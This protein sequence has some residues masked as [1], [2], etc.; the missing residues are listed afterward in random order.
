MT[1]LRTNAEV[2]TG[3]PLV[4]DLD[5]TLICAD[6]LHES[7]L[8][9]L[10]QDP[11]AALRM[12]WWLQ[13]GRA[14]LKHEIAQRVTLDVETLPY[15]TG[16]LEWLKTQRAAGRRLVLCTASNERYAQQVAAHLALFDEVIASDATVNV[17]AQRKAQML[18][19]RFGAKGFDY[20]GNSAD[21]LQV[22]PHARKAIV[23]NAKSSVAAE[24]RQR[25]EV[26]A[27]WPPVK[28]GARGLL[29]AMRLHQWMKNLLLLLPLAGAYQLGDVHLLGQALVAFLAFGLCASSVYV[30][31]DLMDLASDR[32]HPRKRLRPFASGL[33][34]VPQGLVFSA[35]LLAGSVVLALA[36]RPA[37]QAALALYFAMTLAY[38][39]VLKQR[40]IVDCVTLGGL[41]TIRIVAGWCAVGL[42]PSFW[43]L[44]FS[45]FLFLSLAFVKRF[46]ELQLMVKMGRAETR[47]RGY[48]ASDLPIV[49]SMGIAAGFGSVL[50][51][52]LYINGDT[53]L[54]SYTRLELLWCTVPV[55]LYWVSRMWMQAQRG[56][57]HDDPVV[58]A[59]RDWQSVACGALF[60]LALGL[61]R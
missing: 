48:I 38:T 7:T 46:S 39:F 12:P 16:L 4:V 54:R 35:V 45:L 41:Y 37:F 15:H 29:R 56:N 31:N 59:L 30:L 11:I 26:A 40:V 44:A 27:A 33:L 57:M 53:V 13:R 1:M 23:V 28:A 43:L 60:V 21:D 22:W 14:A 3:I 51:L 61:A 6:L 32:A 17:S 24:A 34:S 50:L 19:A 55:H 47:G 8:G 10:R 36:S 25:F 18:V 2:D 58:F 42:P 5:G 52:A 9:L 49:L 20:A